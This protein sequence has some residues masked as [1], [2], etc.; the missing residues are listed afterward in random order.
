MTDRDVDDLIAAAPLT[1]EDEAKFRESVA[2]IDRVERENEN[3]GTPQWSNHTVRR[4]LATLDE[5]RASAVPD[6]AN[7]TEPPLRIVVGMPCRFVDLDKRPYCSVHGGW[8]VYGYC[9]QA[10]LS[11]G[12]KS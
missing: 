7:R 4:L 5:T 1:A 9:D 10:P 3:E 11:D 2:V 12:R 8:W 6:S